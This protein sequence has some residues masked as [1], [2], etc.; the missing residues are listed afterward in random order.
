[1]VPRSGDQGNQDCIADG[2][3]HDRECSGA[4]GGGLAGRNFSINTCRHFVHA[5]ICGRAAGAG[6]KWLIA[7]LA[8]LAWSF[9]A[10]CQ[11]LG[12]FCKM[13]EE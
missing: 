12:E 6:M 4:F 1:M 9:W 13:M 11:E 10:L 2:S 7:I 3:S 5:H 8:V